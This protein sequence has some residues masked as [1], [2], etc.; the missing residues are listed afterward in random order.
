[1]IKQAEWILPIKTKSELNQREHWATSYKRHKLQQLHVSI[2]YYN[3]RPN[4]VLPAHVIFTR[5]GR[6]IDDD[7][8]PDSFKYIRDKLAALILND[9]IPGH[10]D[11]DPRLSWE[12]KQEKRFRPKMDAIKIEIFQRPFSEG[13]TLC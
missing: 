6:K 2:A 4:I 9:P 5:F 13:K 12:Y 10:A 1:M 8:L 11:G 3:L 7:S